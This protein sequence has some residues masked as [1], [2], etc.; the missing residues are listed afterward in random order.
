MKQV[1]SSQRLL[2][3]LSA[4]AVYRPLGSA[5][6]QAKLMPAPPV[7]RPSGNAVGQA[8]LM[9]APPVYR[10]LSNV[11]SQAKLMPAPPVYR[12][13]G[14]A[15]G[16]AK[17]MPT[18]GI[19]STSSQTFAQQ[20]RPIS[21]PAPSRVVQRTRNKVQKPAFSNWWWNDTLAA[22]WGKHNIPVHPCHATHVGQN[23]L[24]GG[25][26][27]IDDTGHFEHSNVYGPYEPGMGKDNHVERQLINAIEVEL[28]AKMNDDT[29]FSD[30]ALAVIEI[31]QWL[32]PC[33]GAHGCTTFL[34]DQVMEFN[35][36]L[37][38]VR[39]G[40]RLSAEFKYNG[41]VSETHPSHPKQNKG[42]VT[43]YHDDN[44]VAF[45]GGTIV[46]NHPAKWW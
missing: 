4:P 3:G 19:A 6:S 46:H 39:A 37:A 14:N 33:S 18:H 44:P 10:P 26:T 25:W 31:H 17:L 45:G 22:T 2:S 15:V 8:K 29:K 11:V 41:G 9:P 7:Y 12:P 5:I 42:N 36:L 30:N 35:G 13:S 32:T 21:S 43:T 23:Q 27:V 16:Q 1:Q 34:N 40:A 24:V 20:A 28:E 38:E